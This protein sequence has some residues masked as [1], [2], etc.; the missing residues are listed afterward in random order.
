MIVI[1]SSSGRTV[2]LEEN[3][4]GGLTVSVRDGREDARSILLDREAAK[5]LSDA[6]LAWLN[7]SKISGDAKSAPPV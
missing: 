7:R 2:T 6:I 4:C 1:S 3:L 5:Q